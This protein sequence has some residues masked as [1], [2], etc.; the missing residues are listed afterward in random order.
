LLFYLFVSKLKTIY[1][2]KNFFWQL[3]RKFW[4]FTETLN[5]TQFCLS[6]F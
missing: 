3:L 4:L 2:N 5:Y 6:T 1:R